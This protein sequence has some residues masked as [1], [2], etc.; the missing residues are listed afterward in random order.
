MLKKLIKTILVST[1]IIFSSFFNFATTSYADDALDQAFEKS[2]EHQI[3]TTKLNDSSVESWVQKTMK[4]LLKITVIIWIA[5]FLYGWIRFLLSMWDESKAKKTRDTLLVSALWLI[6]AFWA[7]A[8]LQLII[9][10]WTTI[11]N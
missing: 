6:I 9:S 10:I 2:K 3:I 1:F 8:I 7:W 11:R 4:L 5:V